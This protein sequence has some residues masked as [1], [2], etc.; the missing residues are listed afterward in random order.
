MAFKY[1]IEA[2]IL[3][4]YT[5]RIYSPLDFVN[6][7]LSARE[8]FTAG[9]PPWLGMAWV[10]WTLPFVWIAVAMS[11]RRAL[12]AG[13]SP[14][15]GMWMLVPLLNFATMIYLAV[16]P[17]SDATL[18]DI[19]D[20]DEI[21][22]Q[23][24]QAW[25]PS[26]LPAAADDRRLRSSSKLRAAAAGIAA[27][28]CYA[29]S[30]TVLSVYLFDSYGA[31]LFFGT[32]AI[33]GAVSAYL[34]NQP[35]RQ[36]I[37]ATIGHT[38]LVICFCCLG[39]L[40]IGLEGAICIAMAIPIMA[41]I[42]IFGALIG[43]AIA[44]QLHR[45]SNDER[46]GLLGC[47]LALPLLAAVEPNVAPAPTFEVVSTVE[48][49]ATPQEVWN[50]VVDFPDIA[51]RPAWFFRMGIASP[52]RA[53]IEGHGVGAVRRCEFT[54]GVF[55]EPITAWNE[56][57]HLAFDVTEQPDPMYELTPYR[58]IHPPHLEG[59][60][61][62]TRGE[63]RLVALPGGRTRLEG[64]TWY[65][66]KIYPLGYWTLWTDWLV[67]QIHRRVLQHIKATAE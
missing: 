8:Q 7:L 13:K 29:V 47:V 19:A 31:A 49:S 53:R 25:Q 55:V 42:A 26:R 60:F 18:P 15:L 67:Q 24:R 5:S 10:L 40:L 22:Q 36:S 66:L 6:P 2:V 1:A 16:V 9:A 4:Y 64:R 44:V 43:R 14:W 54:T 62:S 63:F 21:Q 3:G 45:P 27:G 32:P 17:S 38:C 33:T 28:V 35:V 34:L 23:L 12:D 56:P 58:H 46:L 57:H 65:Q 11:T 50:T 20:D 30:L 41:P 39:F 48:I 37:G 61:Q 52:V 59:A 51:T